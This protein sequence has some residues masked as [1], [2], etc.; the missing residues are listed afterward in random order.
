LHPGQGADPEKYRR[1]HVI[2]GD[3]NMSEVCTYLKVGTTSLVLGTI[4]DKFPG[5]DLS[6]AA[7]E[8]A[9]TR[10]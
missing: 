1:L 7:P 8:R 6:I 2:I 9:G 5:T 10:S 4:E 3:A